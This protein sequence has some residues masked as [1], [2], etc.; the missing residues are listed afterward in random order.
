MAAPRMIRAFAVAVVCAVEIRGGEECDF[1]RNA[2]LAGVRVEIGDGTGEFAEERGV[3][4][5][6]SVVGIE[7]AK[8]GEENLTFH[9]ERVAGVDHAQ[10]HAEL[11]GD[12]VES[13]GRVEAVRERADIGR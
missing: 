7:A 11:A 9:A 13:S 12:A 1:V 4:V 5:E 3:V 6:L 10:D 8:C 2:E